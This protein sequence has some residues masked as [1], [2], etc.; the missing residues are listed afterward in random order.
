VDLPALLLQRVARIRTTEGLDAGFLLRLL[1]SRRFLAHF[2]PDMTGISV[3]H[4]ST[5]QVGAFTF[6]IPE[7]SVQRTVARSLEA[8]LRALQA[9]L[10]A[11]S[12]QLT[13]FAEYRQALITAAV[14]GQ[15]DEATLKGRK[16]ADEALDMELPA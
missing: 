7:L 5:E 3:P 2:E 6:P 4:I 1:Q 12:S 9:A 8:R 10:T 11:I 13:L 14:T 16:P 15:L